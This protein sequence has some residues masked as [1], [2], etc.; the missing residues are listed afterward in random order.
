MNILICEIIKYTLINIYL[1]LINQWL[2]QKKMQLSG[3][4]IKKHMDIAQ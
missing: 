2:W 1:I 4:K 3:I